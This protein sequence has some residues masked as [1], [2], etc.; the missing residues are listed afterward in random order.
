MRICLHF[1]TLFLAL[2][3]SATSVRAQLKAEPAAVDLGRNQQSQTI[4][5]EVKL[6]NSG[7]TVLEI[8]GV[9]ADCSCT[10]ATPEKH[11][12]APNES[13]LLK[14]ALETRGYQGRLHRNV[15]VQTSAGNLTI[16]VELTVS[17][18]KSWM[19]EPSTIVIP[20]SQKGTA[21]EMEVALQYLGQG[22]V[23]LGKITC[24]PDWLQVTTR[25]DGG[26]IFHLKLVKSADAP[27]GNYTVKV[28]LETSDTVEPNI[29]FNVFVP[30][31]SAL[32]VQP[33]PVVL[34][35]VKVGQV[36]SREISIQGWSG[37][38]PAR[39]KLAEGSVKILENDGSKFRCEISVTPTLP[40][41]FTQLLRVYDGEKLETEIPVILRAEPADKVK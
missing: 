40:G 28:A 21:A 41:P 18:F 13:T 20:P 39:F 23:S 30:I 27:A 38:G 11:T 34:P 7:T 26:K 32:R 14:I 8:V 15:Y 16:P 31:T 36:T 29:S 24:T 37:A 9:T 12:L 10:V 6:T 25:I 35:T 5:T 17:L 1:L 4:G 2:A 33:N 22:D 19:L 3:L